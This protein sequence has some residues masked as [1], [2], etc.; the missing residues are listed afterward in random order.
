M[1]K[2]Y[3]KILGVE[4]DASEDVIKKAYKKLAMQYHPDRLVNESEEEKKE[5][6]EKFKEISEAYSVLSDENKRKQYDQFGTVDGDTM[7]FGNM[8]ADDIMQ[9][10]MRMHGF[11]LFGNNDFGSFSHQKMVQKGENIKITLEVTLDE[12]YNQSPKTFKYKR[13]NLCKECN[14]TGASKDSKKETCPSCH[15]TGRITITRQNGFSLFQQISPCERCGGTGYI[16]SNPCPT[17]G[18]SG[19]TTETE[20]ITINIPRGV[21]DNAYISVEG[22]GHCIPDGINGDLFIIFKVKYDANGLRPSQTNPYNLETN[23]EIPV[24]KCITGCETEIIGISGR[25]AVIKVPAGSTNGKLLRLRGYGLPKQDG[26]YGDLLI[27]INQKMPGT[28][29]SDEK[30]LLDKLSK[31]K[32]FK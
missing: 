14:G 26:S 17:C 19:V 8:S 25:K 18:G 27:T 4:K 13:R 24:I 6:E 16:I 30:K 10:F 3:Y 1:T 20:E 31:S 2:D 7:N 5:A 22:K 23:K 15:G 28:I 12:I 21:I 32:N 29:T 9:H 11:D